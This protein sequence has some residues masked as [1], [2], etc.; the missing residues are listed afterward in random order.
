MTRKI[1]G[2]LLGLFLIAATVVPA[3]AQFDQAS[4]AGTGTGTNAQAITLPNATQYSDL[5]GVL[6]K[7]IP[8]G[9]NTGAATLA[10]SGNGGALTGGPIA[11]RKPSGA[12]LIALTG[13]ELITGQPVWIM[14]DGTYFDILS[15]TTSTV[16]AA[17]LANSSLGFSVPVNLQLNASVGSNQLTIAVKGNNGSDPSATNP[18]IFSF[19]DTTIASGDPVIV[20]LSAALSFTIGSGSTMGCVSNQMCRL[21]V[22]AFN[23]AGTVQLCAYNALSGFSV[24]PINEGV[25][26]TSQSGTSGGSTAQLYYCNASAVTNKAARILGYVE[27]SESTAGTWATGPTYVQLFGPG[28]KKPGDVVQRVAPTP[29][30]T[31]T[32]LATTQTQLGITATIVPTSAANIIDVTSNVNVLGG[33]GANGQLKISRGTG[34]SLFGESASFSCAAQTCVVP[35]RGTDTPN[36]TSSTAYYVFGI[37]AGNNIVVNDAAATYAPGSSIILQEIMSSLEPA[38]DDQPLRKVG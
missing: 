26:Q 7:Y 18:V 35:V 33:A 29:N 31:Q 16:T 24:G 27:I 21:W 3:A 20:T 2:I 15:V 10:V 6:I 17:N 8:G 9:T 32:T 38:N 30:T 1:A 28:I 19:R 14:Y 22:L 11:F 5:L 34:P 23:N 4:Y 36:T 13:N 12:G 37:S 25:L